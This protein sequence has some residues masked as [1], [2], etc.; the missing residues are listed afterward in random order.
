MVMGTWCESTGADSLIVLEAICRMVCRLMYALS[1][2]LA[3]WPRSLY[4]VYCCW[5]GW[6]CIWISIIS[7][8]RSDHAEAYGSHLVALLLSMIESLV[9][10]KSPMM[11]AEALFGISLGLLA[12]CVSIALLSVAGYST[13]LM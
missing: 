13:S 3:N 8:N 2:M 10:L 6:R 7:G 4:H 9:K 5:P 1:I 12:Y 11:I